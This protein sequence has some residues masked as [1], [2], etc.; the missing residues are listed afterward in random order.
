[1]VVCVSELPSNQL[2]V[3]YDSFMIICVFGKK[4][5]TL[6][7]KLPKLPKLPIFC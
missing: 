5:V 6:R 3:F 4:D 7:S 2:L 1:M